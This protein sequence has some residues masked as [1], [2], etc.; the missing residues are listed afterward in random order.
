[1]LANMLVPLRQAP[2]L[3]PVLLLVVTCKSHSP[4]WSAYHK[5]YHLT[6]LDH[7]LP[8]ASRSTRVDL[9]GSRGMSTIPL[10][11]SSPG[12]AQSSLHA[13]TETTTKPS[14]R[15]QPPRV[16]STTGL[17]LDHLVPLDATSLCNALESLT[18]NGFAFSQAQVS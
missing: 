17:Q 14:R 9:R 7:L 5:L 18:R 6:W 8:F 12:T 10:T 13:S 11:I 3:L 1:M 15:W 16:T 2:R 4:M